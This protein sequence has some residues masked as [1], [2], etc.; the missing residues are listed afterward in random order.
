MRLTLL[1][2]PEEVCE[3]ETEQNF[4]VILFNIEERHKVLSDLEL[5]CKFLFKEK[6]K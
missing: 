4:N 3:C 5:Y 1:K 6:N 2:N